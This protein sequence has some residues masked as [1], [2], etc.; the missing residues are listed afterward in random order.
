VKELCIT[1]T[2]AWT[3]ACPAFAGK[4]L[5]G[6]KRQRKHLARIQAFTDAALGTS[7]LNSNPPLHAL[8]RKLQVRR[9]TWSAQVDPPRCSGTKSSL[10]LS[11]LLC[12]ACGY[13]FACLFQRSDISCCLIYLQAA[14]ASVEDLPV[15]TPSALPSSGY[16]YYTH[17][18]AYGARRT[19]LRAW[20]GRA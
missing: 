2:I 14:L 11:W 18:T 16:R 4:D 3:I 8:V 15:L 20:F 7:G 5:N 1:R 12:I 17:S 6:P 19:C 13:V 10:Q 9:Y